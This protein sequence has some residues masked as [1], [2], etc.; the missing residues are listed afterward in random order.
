M[1]T[2]KRAILAVGAAAMLLT[3]PGCVVTGEGG[4]VAVVPIGHVHTEFC[5]HY[6]CDDGWYVISGHRHGPGCGHIYIDGRW[7]LHR[8]HGR[9]RGQIKN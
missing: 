7:S 6:W 4:I 1:K 5:G 3:L 2:L 9:H 8:D